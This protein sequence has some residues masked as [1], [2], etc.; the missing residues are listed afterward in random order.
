[1][2]RYTTPSSTEAGTTSPV[3]DKYTPPPPV[4]G[5]SNTPEATTVDEP[6]VAVGEDVAAKGPIGRLVDQASRLRLVREAQQ[7]VPESARPVLERSKE[8]ASRAIAA[9]DRTLQTDEAQHV[10]SS[11]VSLFYALKAFTVML[12]TS[13]V[14]RLESTLDVPAPANTQQSEP[15]ATGPRSVDSHAGEQ[16]R[17]VPPRQEQ[18]SRTLFARYVAVCR[19]AFHKVS[20]RSNQ[21]TSS[22][23]SNENSTTGGSTYDPHAL[24]RVVR[25]RARAGVEFAKDISAQSLSRAARFSGPGSSTIAP[26]AQFVISHLPEDMQ[27]SVHEGRVVE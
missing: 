8:P 15:D 23:E 2:E 7:H 12:L 1:M 20:S 21:S 6:S 13:A 9:V 4:T 19:T 3:V 24:D 17:D 14:T 10:A 22:M 18:Q 25:R 26:A 5:E 11:A 16:D 27:R